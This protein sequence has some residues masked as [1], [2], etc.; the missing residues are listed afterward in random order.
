MAFEIGYGGAEKVWTILEMPHP[1]ITTSTQQTSHL[2]RCMTMVDRKRF[3]FPGPLY[4]SCLRALA[5]SAD[6]ILR[7]KHRVVLFD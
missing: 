1:L 4:R 5:A 3:D 7:L 6:T 2:A